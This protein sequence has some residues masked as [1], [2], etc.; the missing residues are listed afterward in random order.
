MQKMGSTEVAVHSVTKSG[1]KVLCK[2]VTM[3]LAV[4]GLESGARDR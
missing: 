4:Y 1:S 2:M 3:I